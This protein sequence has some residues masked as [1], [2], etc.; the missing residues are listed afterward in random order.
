[1]RRDYSSGINGV[2]DGMG[3]RCFLG[4]AD[5]GCGD[6]LGDLALKGHWGAD[7]F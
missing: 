7:C 6:G 3:M 5:G 2:V 4:A 1:M